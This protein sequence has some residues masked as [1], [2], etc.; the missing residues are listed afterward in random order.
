MGEDGPELVSFGA[1]FIIPQRRISDELR[2][3]LAAEV[4]QVL[5][6]EFHTNERLPIYVGPE[7]DLSY[8]TNGATGE[9]D[10]AGGEW[11]ETIIYQMS[12]RR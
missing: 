8:L 4:E 11:A 10:V 12:V 1:D 7:G 9:P 5:G 2:A 3:T 6:R